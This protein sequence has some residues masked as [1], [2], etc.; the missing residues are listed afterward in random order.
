LGILLHSFLV[1][2]FGDVARYAR[3]TPANVGK[4]REIL[5]RGLELLWKVHNDDNETLSYYRVVVVGHSLGSIIA[6][7]L[8]THFWVEF[9]KSYRL[10]SSSK[11][12]RIYEQVDEVFD[13]ENVQAALKPEYFSRTH[14]S[15]L[16]EKLQAELRIQKK[17][18]WRI[19]DFVTVGSPL[20]H[21][22]FLIARDE[23]A[24][25]ESQRLREMPT[26]PPTPERDCGRWTITYRP[27][28]NAK[29]RLPNHA[30]VF[31]SVR[32][33]NIYCRNWLAHVFLIPGD[34]ISGPVAHHFGPGV[35]DRRVWIWNWK[36]L[37]FAHTA[38]WR[39]KD[40]FDPR[41]PPD[42]IRVLREA[43]K[44]AERADHKTGP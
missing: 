28:K 3:A 29:Q 32:W 6:Y 11:L 25:L 43:V 13:Q 37:L 15:C 27:D 42:H 26:C 12:S 36:T 10:N 14:F 40:S 44:L 9:Y 22:E 30:T 23:R 18:P 31:A 21:A 35:H 39:W 16:Q 17:K 41:N 1:P 34:I 24:L 7:D 38:Y 5:E 4:R 33:T 2:Y 19:T 8:L 20:T